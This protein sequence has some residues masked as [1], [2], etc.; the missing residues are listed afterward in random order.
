MDGKKFL[1][2]CSLE[3]QPALKVCIVGT[4]SNSVDLISQVSTELSEALG[5]WNSLSVNPTNNDLIASSS[6]NLLR[7]PAVTG[8]EGELDLGSI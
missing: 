6:I 2:T 7:K 5:G 3:P 8:M 1:L 4:E